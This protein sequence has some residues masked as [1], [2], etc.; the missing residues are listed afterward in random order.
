[1][2][3]STKSRYLHMIIAIAGHELNAINEVYLNDQELT[4]DTNGFVTAPERFVDKAIPGNRGTS[5]QEHRYINT[6][7][8]FMD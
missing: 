6:W 5:N 7:R 8:T 3:T 2:E 1:M 4:I